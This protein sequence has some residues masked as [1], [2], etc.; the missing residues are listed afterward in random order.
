MRCAL[1]IVSVVLASV[2]CDQMVKSA[3]QVPV[4]AVK[5]ELVSIGKAEARYLVEH[6][7]FGTIE[8]LQ[9]A[10][11]LTGQP[12]RNGYAFTLMVN[13]GEGFNVTAAPSA[14]DKKNWPT[15]VMDQTQQITQR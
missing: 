1:I 11:L 4:I 12:D 6:S 5:L 14:E 8:Q 2:A 7:T 13:G 10:E 9:A 15:F 3:D